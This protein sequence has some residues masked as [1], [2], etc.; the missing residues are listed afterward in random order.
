VRAPS[1]RRPRLV[2][3]KAGGGAY[4]SARSIPRRENDAI[5]V[6]FRAFVVVIA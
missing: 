4:L 6:F 3:D 5:A 1:A 2:I